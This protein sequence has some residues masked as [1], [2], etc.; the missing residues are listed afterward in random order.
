M[1]LSQMRILPLSLLALSLA[2]TGCG[3]VEDQDLPSTASEQEIGSTESAL[4]TG[5]CDNC[6]L[7]AR[8]RQDKLPFGLTYWSDK[9]AVVN[10][11]HAHAGCVAMIPS[12]NSY[13]HAAYVDHVDFAPAPNV[14]YLNEANWQPNACSSRHGSKA[15]LN[16]YNFWCPASAH[17]A[18]CAGPM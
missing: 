16:I 11:N 5:Y 8:C 1:F 12:S 2:V 18:N 15:G 6:V 7:Y 14:I 3:G 10:S 13:G 9:K 4:C 17:T